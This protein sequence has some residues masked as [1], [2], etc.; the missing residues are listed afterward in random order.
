[1]SDSTP[2]IPE[3]QAGESPTYGTTGYTPD[4]EEK[5]VIQLVD[6]LYSKA[7]KYRKRYDERWM[8]FYKMFRGK[9]WK[10]VRPSYRSSEVMNLVFE[11]IQAMVPIL[12]DSHPKLQF[13]PTL[14]AQFELADILNKVAENDWS[15]NNWLMVLT[16]IL[17]DAHFYGTGM[18]YVG[19]NPKAEMGL[20]AIEFES[21]DIFYAFPDPQARDVNGKRTKYW[22]TAEPTDLSELK[23]L[24]PEK[25]K[26]L[27]SDVIDLAN[28][29]K[30]DIQNVMFKS[31][32]D[33]KLILEGPSSGDTA[34]KNQ[35]LKITLYSKDD[36]FD[37]DECLDEEADGTPKLDENGQ[38][39]KK[40]VQTLK[41]PKGRKVVV[42]GGVLC[43]DGEMEF[44]DGL[45]P[46]VKI[47]N[48]VLPREFWGMGEVEQLEGPQKTFNKLLSF[49]LDTMSLM[50][51]PIYIVDDTAGIDTDN[52][53][54]KP[55]LVI[56]KAQGSEVRRES[57]VELPGF[58][59][60][61][62]D[63]YRKYFDGISGSTD[64]SR[65]VESTSVTAASAIENL[66]Q[67]QQTRL[68]LKSRNIDAFLQDFGKLYLSRVFQYYSVPRIVRVSGDQNADKYFYF[69]VEQLETL[70][71]KGNKIFKKMAHI[72]QNGQA[73]TVEIEGEFDV[74]VSTGSSLPF[75]KESK[76]Q[77][78]MNLFKLEVIDAEELLKD[79]DYPNYE[80]VL[81]RVNAKKAEA[82]QGQMQQQQQAM[83]MQIAGKQAIKATPVAPAIPPPLGGG[84]PQ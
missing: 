62:I 41:Y 24:Y 4:E 67:A 59:L 7:K 74:R 2:F 84:P 49:V 82:A 12:T 42:A 55:G 13:L 3:H 14:P 23:K 81:Q 28:G 51:N 22:I 73:K 30:S 38:P 52:L 8:D 70:D 25:A 57:G 72:N 50:S 21:F 27:T 10:E 65:G 44:D 43:E 61:L 16:E 40:Y 53:F 35:A 11:T 19:F 69:H 66:Q 80:L 45:F 56:E 78:A 47:N 39:L 18:A 17:F 77:M 58:I 71:E 34:S 64:L 26:W 6:N 83:E 46:F 79:L 63:R 60:P 9:Q 15:H 68:R 31:P 48:Y 5:E 32:M 37:E 33:S 1:M 75:A 76:G 20:G 29:D 36:D 54:N